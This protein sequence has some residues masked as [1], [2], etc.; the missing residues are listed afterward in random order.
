MWLIIYVHFCP[1]I[2]AYVPGQEHDVSVPPNPNR[3]EPVAILPFG[4][5]ALGHQ[6][7]EPNGELIQMMESQSVPECICFFI[8][9]LFGSIIQSIS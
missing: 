2:M 9:A 5:S 8:F 7:H 6:V 3:G 4:W 1:M